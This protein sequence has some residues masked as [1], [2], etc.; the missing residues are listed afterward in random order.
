MIGHLQARDRAL[1]SFGW[2][3]RTGDRHSESCTSGANKFHAGRP[4]SHLP[5]ESSFA[6]PVRGRLPGAAKGALTKPLAATSSGFLTVSN[7]LER[8]RTIGNFLQV[9]AHADR[10]SAFGHD[11][12]GRAVQNAG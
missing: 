2:T 1:G 3:G 12:A 11:V 10:S 9:D 4:P 6:A 5:Y 8:Y 7:V